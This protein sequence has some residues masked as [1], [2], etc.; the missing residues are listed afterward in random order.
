[1]KI[2]FVIAFICFAAK[3]F[4]FQ[5]SLVRFGDLEFRNALEKETL[6]SFQQNNKKT[7]I[8]DLFMIHFNVTEKYSAPS[9]LR[10]IDEVVEYLK[11]ETE[12]LSE[13]KKIKRI[14]EFVH[15]RFFKVYQHDNSF[16]D[17]FKNGEYNCVSGSA[18]YGI[19]LHKMDI[20]Y[21]IVEAP[22]HVFLFAYPLSHK[23][24]IET[25]S[26]KN[27]YLTFNDEYIQRFIKYLGENKLISQL[28]IDSNSAKT[29]FEKY[30][31]NKNGLTIQQLAAI[32]YAN[33]ASYHSEKS[34]YEKALVEIKK[35]YFLDPG[36][37]NAYIMQQ[38]LLQVASNNSY[39]EKQ[40]FNNLVFLCR[41]NNK[42]AKE[43]SNE[44]IKQEFGRLTYEQLIKKADHPSYDAAFSMIYP[45][46]ADSSLRADIA[47]VYHYELARIGLL[48][49]KDRKYEI[50]H[51]KAAYDL[52]PKHVD[53][54]T[55]VRGLLGRQ[56]DSNND[57]KSLMREI[58]DF[59]S[60]FSFLLTDNAFN[61]VRSNCY[62]EYAYQLIVLNDITNGEIEL[63]KFEKLCDQNPGLEVSDRFVEKAY[64]S[65]ATYYFKKGNKAKSKEVL[66]RGLKYAPNN[67]GLKVR[68]S[69]VR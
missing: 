10:Q 43:V 68:L 2:K 67:F 61:V 1:M 11:K 9:S 57:P 33:F 6:K 52:N 24:L 65:A 21:Q 31:F 15:K 39:S 26:P 58:D 34:E 20:P 50:E 7:N 29:L 54:Q 22:Q 17:V 16:P 36:E 49:Y 4:S 44:A 59:A 32:Q 25:T 19:I 5:D 55:M 28:E 46:V 56:I 66:T 42:N 14:Y 23:I 18:M 12:N 48:N 45:E 53:L 62:L 63:K 60:Q 64:S 38:I 47:F 27:G 37:R 51:L 40:E 30:Y 35:A 69:Q 13:P 3:L 41:Y 8:V